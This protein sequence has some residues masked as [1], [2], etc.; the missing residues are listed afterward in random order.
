M[1]VVDSLLIQ[2][3]R[4]HA[5]LHVFVLIN[6]AVLV[7]G[8]GPL[9]LTRKSKLDRFAVFVDAVEGELAR[10]ID[11]ALFQGSS[12]RPLLLFVVCLRGSCNLKVANA[13]TQ[14]EV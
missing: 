14:D 6:L 10:L 8:Y 4:H 3:L 5:H 1:L 2:D 11:Y 7:G 9:L 12:S 13:Y